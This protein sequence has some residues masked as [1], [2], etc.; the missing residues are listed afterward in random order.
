[1]TI[2]KICDYGLGSIR[3]HETNSNDWLSHVYRSPEGLEKAKID[4]SS[5]SYS[6]GIIFSELISKK[7]SY[8]KKGFQKFL[9]N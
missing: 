7:R 9:A 6:F 4:P 1:M 5:D 3:S 2:V 8:D